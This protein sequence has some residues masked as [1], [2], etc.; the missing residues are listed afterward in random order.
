MVALPA[1]Y[2]A[3]LQEAWKLMGICASGTKYPDLT[4]MVP[5]DKLADRMA[6][7]HPGL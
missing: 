6:C 4:C 3:D 7:I 2:V 5:R 1:A